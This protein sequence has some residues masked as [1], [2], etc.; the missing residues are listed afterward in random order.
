M[1]R[2]VDRTSFC[3]LKAN[4][5]TQI[6]AERSLVLK[7]IYFVKQF[8]DTSNDKMKDYAKANN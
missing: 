6:L 8:S 7:N 4:F 3:V 1:L 2:I 5:F